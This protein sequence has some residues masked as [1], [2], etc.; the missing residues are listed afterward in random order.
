MSIFRKLYLVVLIILPTSC[1]TYRYIDLEVLY[2]GTIKTPARSSF[3]IIKNKEVQKKCNVDVKDTTIIKINY[4][5]ILLFSFY[6]GFADKI[7]TFDKF[8]DSKF[9]IDSVITKNPRNISIILDSVAVKQEIFYSYTSEEMFYASLNLKK[10]IN[11]EIIKYI[12]NKPTFNDTV[13]EDKRDYYLNKK[14]MYDFLSFKKTLGD[15][16]KDA[17]EQ[18]A[19]NFAPHWGTEERLLYYNNNR[20]FRKGYNSFSNNNLNDAVN[21]WKY[22]YNVGTPLLASLSA[23]NIALTFE[24]NDNLDSC[25]LWLNNSLRIQTHPQTMEYLKRIQE[26]KAERIKLENDGDQ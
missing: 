12:D 11:C 15:I 24:M 22:L 5:D 13:I 8:K 23:H 17:G 19:L 21:Q 1:F 4:Y 7:K 6:A 10:K 20:F 25:E 18:C 14:S 9:E 26:R 16:G 2:P 3:H